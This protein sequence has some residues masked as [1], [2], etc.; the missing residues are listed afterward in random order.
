M[1]RWRQSRRGVNC[2]KEVEMDK[3]IGKVTHYYSRLGV[4][5]VEL[6]GELEIGDVISIQG[7][8]TDL[9]Q[10][11]LS[12]EINHQKILKAGPHMEVAMKVNDPVRSG[13]RIFKVPEGEELQQKM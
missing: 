5:V 7:H 4:A 1:V 8:T 13:D 12:L 10:K 3:L 11:V 6:K 9:V 2:S